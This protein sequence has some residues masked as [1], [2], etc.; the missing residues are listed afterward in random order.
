MEDSLK[1]NENSQL[2]KKSK[3]MKIQEQF[4]KIKQAMGQQANK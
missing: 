1:E 3:I 2:Q 4:I